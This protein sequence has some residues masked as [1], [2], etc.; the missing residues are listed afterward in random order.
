MGQQ[1]WDLWFSYSEL[2]ELAAVLDAEIVRINRIGSEVGIDFDNHQEQSPEAR[3]AFLQR[4]VRSSQPSQ[5]SG[6]QS[7]LGDQQG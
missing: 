2:V 5:S 1:R 7:S 3:Q 4:W 6:G